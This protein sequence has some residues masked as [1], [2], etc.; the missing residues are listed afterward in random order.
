MKKYFWTM[1]VM[2]VFAI[3]F[4]ASDDESS[5]TSTSTS[6]VSEKEQTVS[7]T[8]EEVKPKVFFEPGYTYVSNGVKLRWT[9]CDIYAYYEMKIYKDGTVDVKYRQEYPNHEYEDFT[10]TSECKMVKFYESKR[11]VVR[12]G[13][14][15]SGSYV[16]GG[17]SQ[18]LNFGVD[19]EGHI[20]N[21]GVSWE[22]L[23]S[24]HDGYFTK[25]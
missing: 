6:A 20:W 11:D 3:G 21:G 10:V 22:T 19:M 7:E 25:Q 15:I 23:G 12:E 9:T 1:A 24:P 8:E 13:Y 2:A 14:N 4:A 16:Y 5:N 18:G 17:R